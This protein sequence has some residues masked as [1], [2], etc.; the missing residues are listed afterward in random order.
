MS[1]RLLSILTIIAII[2]AYAVS[3][4]GEIRVRPGKF[5]RFVVL[6]PDRVTAG[7]N[8]EITIW[9]VDTFGNIIKDFNKTD[10]E[11]RLSATGSATINPS[12]FKSAAFADG[13]L[14]MVMKDTVSETVTLSLYEGNLSIPLLNK[15]IIISPA[16]LKSFELKAPVRVVAGERFEVAISAKDMYNNIVSEDVPG[17]NLNFAFTGNVDPIFDNVIAD[18]KN[19]VGRISLVSQKTGSLGIEVSDLI[20]GSKGASGMI[21]VVSGSADSF[22]IYSPKEV[23][24]GEPF[25]ISL[26]A[27]DRFGNIATDY[28]SAGANITLASSGKV[29]PFPSVIPA[30]EFSNGQVKVFIRYDVPETVSITASELGKKTTG[31][32]EVINVIAPVAE[33]FEIITP[34]TVSA[35]QKFKIK[36]T[37]YNQA[38]NIIKNY[39]VAGLDVQLETTGTGQL[40]PSLIPASEFI[41]GSAIVE[42]QYNKSEIFTISA[43]TVRVETVIAVKKTAPKHLAKPAAFAKEPA[44]SK[45]QHTKKETKVKALSTLE[46]SS[47]S[48]VEPKNKSSVAIHIPNLNKGIRYNAYTEVIDGKKWI[49][50]K[51]SPVV[52][53]IEKPVKFD[54][55]F[56]G[57]VVVESDTN[58]KNV[59]YIKLE[60]L[61]P[62]KFNMVKE[63]NS[64][65]IMLKN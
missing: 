35:G 54:S 62:T 42:V 21:T 28:S 18:L 12:V 47:I 53:K 4:A 34:A 46:I 56:I 31:T 61:K 51:I 27:L 58:D 8:A 14:T 17:K 44:K 49:I 20:S 36:I 13:E 19:G 45:K 26:V 3:Y 33:K 41:N 38:G 24:A 2:A 10:K 23:I 9:A 32:S 57:E 39:N 40:T 7:D 11:F 64:L 55:K 22:K 5:D 65:N 60:L 1:R 50:V 37:A 52:N 63:K 59:V 30:H 16:A 6:S 43:R 29:K 48:M 15:S 25:E